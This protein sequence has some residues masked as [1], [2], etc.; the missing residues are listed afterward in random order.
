ML[1]REQPGAIGVADLFSR[2]AKLRID[3]LFAELWHNEDVRNY[4]AAQEMLD[5][6]YRWLEEGIIE[7]W[8]ESSPLADPKDARPLKRAG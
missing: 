1:S 6:R 2:Q 7:S 8:A 4:R 3:R 5:A